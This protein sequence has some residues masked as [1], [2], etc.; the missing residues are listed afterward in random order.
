MTTLILLDSICLRP[1]VLGDLPFHQRYI[2]AGSESV[3]LA[4][5]EQLAIDECE[6]I[7]RRVAENPR[8]PEHVLVDLAVDDVSDVRSSVAEH[9]ATPSYVLEFLA[10]DSCAD[11]R[12]IIAE[13]PDTPRHVLSILVKDHNPFVACRASKTVA[14]LDTSRRNCGVA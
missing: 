10:Q 5:L 2:T 3:S 13:N 14:T 8:T 12:F 6:A 9:Q 4:V 1:E 11:V 7:R